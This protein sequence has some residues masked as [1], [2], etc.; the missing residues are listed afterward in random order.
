MGRHV[1]K[2]IILAVFCVFVVGG[3]MGCFS[4]TH[5][6]KSMDLAQRLQYTLDRVT[7]GKNVH[8]T[9][10]YVYRGSDG[11]EWNGS[12][13]NMNSGSR[14]SIASVTKMYTAAVILRLIEERS[15]GWDDPIANFLPPDTMKNLHVYEGTDYSAKITIRDLLSHTSGLPDYFSE[16]TDKKISIEEM[17]K[18][19]GDVSYTIDDVLDKTKTLAPHF[20][21]GSKGKAYY[22]DGNYQ[23][24]G[25][26]IERVT[27][28]PLNEIYQDFIFTPLKLENTYLQ[29]DK[30]QWGIAP[31]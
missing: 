8:G 29:V 1:R 20:A 19:N 10:F 31:I 21:P 13:G 22:S 11:F 15:L 14:Y 9:A 12:S 6:M 2:F 26:I 7:D 30:T 24:L 25:I 3:V 23:L 27:G 17:R 18:T 28:R 4:Y 16:S 5:K